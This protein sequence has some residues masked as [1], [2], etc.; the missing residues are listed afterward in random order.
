MIRQQNASA[1]S[2][3]T[4]DELLLSLTGAIEQTALLLIQGKQVKVTEDDEAITTQAAADLLNVSRPHLV[5][6]LETGV[7]AQ[8]PDTGVR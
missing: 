1:T 3:A 5:K 6:L 2:A 7:I 8:L 4:L